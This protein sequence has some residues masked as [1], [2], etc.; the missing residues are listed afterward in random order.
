MSDNRHF[1]QLV[2]GGNPVGEVI[3][4]DHFLVK[5]KGLH[6]VSLHALIMFEDGSK[7]FVQHVMEDHVVVLQL[8]SGTITVGM[9]AVIQ[10]NELVAKV[11][12]DFIGR[13]ISVTG[14]PLDEKGPIAADAVWP[15]FYDAP[16]LYERELLDRQLVTGVTVIDELFPILRGQ[17]LAVLGD[18]KSGKSTLAT[19]L[20]INQKDTDIVVIYAM[21]AKRRTDVDALL[22]R[23]QAN[24]AL[25]N[26]IVVVSTMADSLILSYLAPYVAC[27]MGEYLWQQCDTDVLVVYD[28]LTN[29]AHAYREIALLSGMSPGRDSFPG[30][31]F[32]VHSSLLERAGKLARNHKSLTALPLV[33][34]AGGDITA[35]LPTNVMSITDG[36]WVLD[37]DIF[38]DTMRP[39]V[40]IGLS[41]TRVGGRGQNLRQKQLAGQTFKVLTSYAQ[42]QEFSHFGS[43]LAI[44]AQRDLSRGQ[45][46]YKVLNQAPG[47]SYSLVA[48]TL[49]MDITL[50]LQDNEMLDVSTLKA[51]VAEFA[52]K[53][54]KDEEFEKVRDELKA[55]SL[56]E[57]KK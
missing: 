33:L 11:G 19:Q 23:L 47:E 44:A 32:Y 50:N 54:T 3:S 20:A 57:L 27:A 15:V 5:V 8:G 38:R 1:D 10:H 45:Q 48:Q 21:I 9:L 4:I 34:A 55:K 36:Q 39:A 6:P 26:A 51:N 16:M 29:H 56:V 43:E 49:M 52:T 22:T 13:V 37:M 46:M 30:D 25:K 12:K 17:R 42:A 41:V 28:D 35:F 24:D 14:D 7:G 53:V 18:S 40:S 31:M 2:S